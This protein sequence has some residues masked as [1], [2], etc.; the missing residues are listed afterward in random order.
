[1]EIHPTA[2]IARGAKIGERV[3]IG[4]QVSIGE[5]VEIGDDC[6]I[7]QGVHIEGWTKIGPRNRISSYAV[8]GTP[9]Q[10]LKFAD[11]KSEL[12]IGAD[13][14]IHEFVT[15]NRATTHGGGFTQ[16]GNHNFIMAY[17]HI[18]HD[19]LVGDHVI[20][21]NAATLAGHV[22][23]EDNV[24][25]GGLTGVH[26]FVSIGRYAFIGGCSAVSQDIVPYA[27]AQGNHARILGLNLVGLKRQGFSAEQLEHLKQVYRVLFRTHQNRSLAMAFIKENLVLSDEVQHVIAFIEKSRRG[28]AKG[29]QP[30]E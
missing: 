14:K 4:P 13:N 15:I 11:E 27:L 21:A 16:V 8:L 1:M 28:M 2:I 20:L 5:N 6:I 9:P 25:I 12:I 30:K 7:G 19:C 17:V 23:V 18:A 29:I 24:S 3:S 10:D 22:I 26:Q